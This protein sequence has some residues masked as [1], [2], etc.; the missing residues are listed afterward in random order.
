MQLK[1]GPVWLSA[2]I[3]CHD[4]IVTACDQKIYQLLI[5][6]ILIMLTVQYIVHCAS[7][8]CYAEANA[9]EYIYSYVKQLK[10]Q[11]KF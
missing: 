1:Y 2:V 11:L 6:N 3:G 9:A 4:N 7:P 5:L 10:S 8:L